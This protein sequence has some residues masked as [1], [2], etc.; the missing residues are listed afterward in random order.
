[1]IKMQ[2]IAQA[3]WEEKWGFMKHEEIEKVFLSLF[4]LKNNLLQLLY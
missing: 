3:A 2:E 1:M 4:N